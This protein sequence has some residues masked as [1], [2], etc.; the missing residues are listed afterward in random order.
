[1]KVL[2]LAYFLCL[3]TFVTQEDLNED[4]CPPTWPKLKNYLTE[5]DVPAKLLLRKDEDSGC[6]CRESPHQWIVCFG[7]ESCHKFPRA[8]TIST[9]ILKI[10]NTQIRNFNRD[11]LDNV[12]HLD[13]LDVEANYYL[14]KIEAGTFRNMTMLTNMSI[15]YNPNLKSLEQD[16]FVGLINLKELFL[17]KNGFTNVIDITISLA[18]NI[19]PNLFKLS[20]SENTFREINRDDFTSMEGSSLR[21]L[22]LVLCQTD[23]IHFESLAPLTN[24]TGI[25]LGENRF[26]T[27]TIS[28]LITTSIALGIPLT[29]INL[30]AVGFRKAPPKPL[31]KA[32]ANSSITHLCMARNQFEVIQDNI[33]PL[34]PKLEYL[35]LREVLTLN[36]TSKAFSS[37]PKLHTLL[38]S[39]NKLAYVPDGVLLEQL[40]Y[41]D[42]SSNSGNSYFPSYF[43]LGRKKFVKM[44]NLKYL[45][46]SFN[47]INTLLRGTFVGLSKLRVLGLRNATVYHI[48]NGAFAPLKNLIVLNLKNNP[49]AKNGP[50]RP[51]MFEGLENLEVLLLGGCSISNISY[52]NNPFENLTSLIHLG[53]EDN[54]ILNLSPDITDV[55]PHLQTI[56]ISRNFLS[57]WQEPMFKDN[58]NLTVIF[59]AHNK[60]SYLSK[61]MLQ[62]F[63]NLSRLDISNNPFTCECSTFLPLGDWLRN[64]ERTSILELIDKNPGYCVYPDQAGDETILEYFDSLQNGTRNCDPLYQS[65]LSLL[66]IL[67]FAALGIIMLAIGTLAY[68]YRWHI[69]YWMFLAR[70]NI[71][72]YGKRKTKRKFHS[73][74]NYQ[75]DAFVSYSNEDRNF[76]IRLVA[77]LENFEPFL[78]LCVYERDFQIGTVISETVLESV[79]Q[80]R[81]TLLII[82]DSYA[83]SQW[84]RWEV[85]IAENHRLFFE[86]DHGEY[87]DD[88]LVMIRLGD[89][90]DAHMTPTLKYLMKTRIYLQWDQDP[91]KQKA[92]WEKLRRTLAPPKVVFDSSV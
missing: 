42:L 59:A 67:P 90:S 62:D 45:N 52:Y 79:A 60:F 26:N 8:M 92:F 84:C 11:D 75:Y 85:Q 10:R 63:S 43:S 1:M 58:V 57:P 76:V 24:L 12:T 25:R 37:L 70:I 3:Y 38:L 9:P 49:F 68:L 13:S 83:R 44:K 14:S 29:L 4:F 17:M 72:R 46:L 16:T 55:L 65:Q 2:F 7:R 34:M 88:S 81:R 41:L 40:T 15:S 36:I 87:V 91:K 73:Y 54:H 27:T 23:Y 53:L 64:S 22:N 39:G 69:R 82:S 71:H 21:E 28:E 20:L 86:N 74:T 32:I 47:Q 80:S 31:L 51:E 50:L 35:D 61:A 6:L 5:I 89:V 33:F 19:L 18:P 78:K 30:Y 77:M 56:D 48:A 66:Y